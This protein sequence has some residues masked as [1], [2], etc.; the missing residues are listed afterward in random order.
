M[1]ATRTGSDVM[2]PITI[3]FVFS[4]LASAMFVLIVL[5]VISASVMERQHAKGALDYRLPGGYF[6][7]N[8][9]KQDSLEEFYNRKIVKYKNQNAANTYI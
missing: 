8:G 4:L 7:I 6:T 2:K 3:L 1:L 5:P 9:R